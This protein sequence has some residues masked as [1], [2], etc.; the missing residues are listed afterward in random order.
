MN[1]DH[2]DIAP[3]ICMRFE[4]S[5]LPD[6]WPARWRSLRSRLIPA[7]WPRTGAIGNVINAT[8]DRS[9]SHHYRVERVSSVHILWSIHMEHS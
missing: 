7:H 9:E 1:S 3:R 8:S 6:Y 2:F 5:W 4:G